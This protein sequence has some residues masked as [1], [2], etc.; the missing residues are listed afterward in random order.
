M[1]SLNCL[2]Y[3]SA[4]GT[5]R[6]HSFDCAVFTIVDCESCALECSLVCSS[7]MRGVG[8]AE[9]KVMMSLCQH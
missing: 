1:F 6:Y 7:L 3:A 8:V 9:K 5:K 2:S 4:K